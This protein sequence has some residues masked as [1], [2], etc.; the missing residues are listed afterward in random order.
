MNYGRLALAAIAAWVV[1]AVYGFVVYGT[2]LSSEFGRYPGVY[3]PNEVGPS[4]LPVIF[5]G[6]LL[7]M[8]VASYVY[9]KGYEGGSGIQEGMRFGVL[10]GLLVLGYS[11]IVNYAIL[12]IGRRLAGSV[13][14]A[15]LVEWTIAG[16]VIGAVYK[17]AA[18]FKS[19]SAVMV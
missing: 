7:A 14:I 17:P 9:A 4:Y 8:F 15:G 11:G 2:V 13:A 1:D 18:Q 10:M 6:I 19:R 3:R 16:I 12:N 5:V